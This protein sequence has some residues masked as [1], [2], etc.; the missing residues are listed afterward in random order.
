M[1][2]AER[3]RLARTEALFREVNERIAEGARRFEGDEAR[4]VCECSDPTCTDRI[5]ATL[6][7][8]ERVRSDGATFLLRTG[9]DVGDVEEVV[10]EIH[11]QAAIVEKTEPRMRQIVLALDPRG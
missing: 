5:E 8:Y 4:F 9:H 11:D 1:A 3:E 2:F 6:V 10:D 7:D